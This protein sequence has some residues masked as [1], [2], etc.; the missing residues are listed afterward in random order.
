MS[1]ATI[2]IYG[3]NDNPTSSVVDTKATIE[4]GTEG[5]DYWKFE[6]EV[7]YIRPDIEDETEVAEYLNNFKFSYNAIRMKYSLEFKPIDFPTTST[8]ITTLFP[9]IDV[10]S[11]K[12]L[13]LWL[14]DYK[15]N[16]YSSQTTNVLQVISRGGSKI[17]TN[18]G[19]KIFKA[20]F[21]DLRQGRDYS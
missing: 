11:C 6:D 1:I 5:T 15:I 19:K 17:D 9:F 8:D 20:E 18:N 4:A 7:Y 14:N 16:V 21:M 3:R 2:A 10:L 12:Y 13:W